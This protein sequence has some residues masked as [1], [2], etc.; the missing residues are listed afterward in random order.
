MM[1]ASVTIVS[2]ALGRAWN[3]ISSLRPFN[4]TLVTSAVIVFLIGLAVHDLMSAR[5]IH[6]ATLAGAALLI[7]LRAFASLIATSDLG[8]QFV[9]GLG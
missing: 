6:P 3:L 1:V 5:R 2:P 4:S 7:A 8:Q 9:R